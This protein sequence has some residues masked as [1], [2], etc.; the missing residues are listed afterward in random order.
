MLLI[1][2]FLL[3]SRI[4]SIL[5]FFLILFCAEALFLEEDTMKVKL[6][7]M[8]GDRIHKFS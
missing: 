4:S 7:K 8:F 3:Q 5:L 6:N 1:I 2:L